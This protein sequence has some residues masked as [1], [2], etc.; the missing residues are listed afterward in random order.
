M[1]RSESQGPVGESNIDAS[2]DILGDVYNFFFNSFARD[3]IDNHGGAL[4]GY[5]YAPVANAQWD[6]TCLLYTSRCV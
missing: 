6:G 1:T 5:V 4:I 3:G 2:Y